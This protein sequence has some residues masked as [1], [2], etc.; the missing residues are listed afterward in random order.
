[1]GAQEFGEVA[2]AAHPQ[3]TKAQ[4]TQMVEYILSLA[5][6]EKIKSLPLSGKA[7]FAMVPPPGRLQ[8]QRMFLP[9]PMKIMVPMECLRCQQQNKF[10]LKHQS[11]I[12]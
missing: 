3:L 5:N 7:N 8:L 9:L 12:G 2:M 1:M 4:T 6:E 11:L 10:S